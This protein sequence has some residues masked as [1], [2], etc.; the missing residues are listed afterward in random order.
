[1]VTIAITGSI[2]CGKSLVGQYLGESGYPVCDADAV[3]HELMRKGGAV[4]ETVVN[5]F[6]RGVLNDRGEIDRG[7]LGQVV[8]ADE[9][10]RESL[11]RIVH[12]AVDRAIRDWLAVQSGSMAFAVVPL[13]FESAMERGW[14]AVVCV[15]APAS[16]QEERLRSRNGLS[17]EEARARIAAQWPSDRKAE[18][19][20][21]VLVNGGSME[22][23]KEQTEKMLERIIGEY[24]A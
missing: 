13:L 14:D 17:V 18:R 12:P 2:A 10:A 5:R 19:S 4:Y 22:L 23:L 3:A 15:T 9:A 1:M 21:F 6:S 16:V 11:N 8:F 20:D 24:H 7:R